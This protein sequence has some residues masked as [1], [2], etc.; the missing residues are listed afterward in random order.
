MKRTKAKIQNA[1]KRMLRLPDL[2]H[3]FSWKPDISQRRRSIYDWRPSAD[4]L[5]KRL[6]LDYLARNWRQVSVE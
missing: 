6:T 5:T 3:A 2:D 4:W 1:P